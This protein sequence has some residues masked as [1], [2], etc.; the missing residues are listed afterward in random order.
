[1]PANPNPNP[2]HE[3]NRASE[4][5]SKIGQGAADYDFARSVHRAIEQSQRTG[6]KSKVIVT[7]EIDPD[8][9]RGCLILRAFVTERLPKLAPPA[10]QMHVSAD[11]QLLTQQEFILGGGPSE[12][13]RILPVVSDGGPINTPSGRFP[14]AGLPV[15]GPVAAT[16]ARQP[17]VGKDAAAG[18]EN[19]Q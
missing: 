5:L 1:M 2:F 17:L 7:V 15:R 4:I 8:D 14:V 10:S 3:A 9:D 12:K 11:G 18:K 16:P 6:K 19:D 13:P